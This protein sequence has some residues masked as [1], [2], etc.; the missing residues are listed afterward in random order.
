MPDEWKELDPVA[1]AKIIIYTSCKMMLIGTT[2]VL[3]FSDPMV[4]VL[5]QIGIVTG[6]GSF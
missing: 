3:I 6:V 1:R 2:V 4:D 5:N